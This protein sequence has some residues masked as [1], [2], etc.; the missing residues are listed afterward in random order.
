MTAAT[1]ALPLSW[2]GFPAHAQDKPPLRLLV[3]F[4]P[5]GVGVVPTQAGSPGANEQLIVDCRNQEFGS[6]PS[7]APRDSR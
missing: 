6:L 2:I 1:L 5:G 3:G 4:P 7:R